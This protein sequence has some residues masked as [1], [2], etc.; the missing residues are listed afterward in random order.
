MQWLLMSR[1]GMDCLWQVKHDSALARCL[2]A[3]PPQQ[4]SLLTRILARASLKVSTVTLDGRL[5][6]LTAREYELLELLARNRYGVVTR[7][8][9]HEQLFDE[10]D[11]SM[12]NRLD[13]YI[14]K[15]RQKF[16]KARILTRRGMG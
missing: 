11:D 5:V 7:W 14:Y 1:A 13:V 4:A 12:S 10:R 16:G 6:A 8:E 9:M 2:V 3:R 15:L